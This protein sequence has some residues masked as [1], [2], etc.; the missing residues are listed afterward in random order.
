MDI[1][2]SNIYIYHGYKEICSWIQSC[3]GTS[4]VI[5]PTYS[6]PCPSISVLQLCYRNYSLK[7]LILITKQ[8]QIKHHILKFRFQRLNPKQLEPA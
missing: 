8:L 4:Q 7:L 2:L 1:Q 6:C 3:D 5:R